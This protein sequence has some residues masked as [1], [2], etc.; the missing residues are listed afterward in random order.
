MDDDNF[1]LI[2]AAGIIPI[3]LLTGVCVLI[4]WP[5]ESWA[6]HAQWDR[7]GMQVEYGPIEDCMVKTAKGWV[8]ADSY[9]AISAQ[10]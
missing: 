6:C 4:A 3:L 1:F 10:P 7:S 8:P 5:F 2:A 9:K